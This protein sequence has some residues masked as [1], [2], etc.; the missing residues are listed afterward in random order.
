MV[1]D[2]C[3]KILELKSEEITYVKC[4]TIDISLYARNFF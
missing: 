3:A 1:C 4:V 2:N